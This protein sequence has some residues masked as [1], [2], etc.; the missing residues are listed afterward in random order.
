MSD[1]ASVDCA[2]GRRLGCQTFCCRLLVRLEPDE[3]GPDNQGT[4]EKAADGY[5]VHLDREHHLCR[6]WDQR[7]RACRGY[8]CNGDFLLQ[9]AVR[10]QFSNIV[11]LVRLAA[12]A[13]IPK[14]TYISVPA[15][16]PPDPSTAPA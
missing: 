7:S 6:I 1:Y 11:E 10:N 5:C 16:E 8:T 12:T 3:R 14:E 15:A 4:V 9:V 2:E 13:Y